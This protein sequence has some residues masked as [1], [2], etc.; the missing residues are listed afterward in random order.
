MSPSCFNAAE[1]IRTS[2]DL[3]VHKAELCVYQFRHSR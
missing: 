3:T 2:T 1:R